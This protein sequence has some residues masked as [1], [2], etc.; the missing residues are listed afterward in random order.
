MIAAILLAGAGA[1]GASEHAH[2]HAAIA[3]PESVRAE[4]AEIHEALHGL[5]EAQGAVGEA[6][7][8]LGAVLGPHFEREEQIA[9][10]PLGLLE[11]LSRGERPAGADAALAM[12]DALRRELPGML[13]EH[14][15]I[16][17]AVAALRDAA[18]AAGD[19]EAERFAEVLARHAKTEEEVLYPA[20]ILVGDVLR[21]PPKR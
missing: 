17:A 16:R 15:R 6:A 11:P 3:I 20:A 10:P 5:M 7:R 2:G 9:L 8:K 4:H 14:V 21:K 19:R 13:E 1:L 18:R 12:S